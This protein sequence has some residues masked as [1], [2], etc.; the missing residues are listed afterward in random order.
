MAKKKKLPAGAKPR[1]NKRPHKWNGL[2]GF[3]FDW[4][5][6]TYWV[7]TF[8]EAGILDTIV[9]NDEKR[10]VVTAFEDFGGTGKNARKPVITPFQ[11]WIDRVC[12]EI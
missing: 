2:D 8:S 3:A 4:K 11:A 6:K 7:N 5:D 12:R 9:L 10:A 1:I